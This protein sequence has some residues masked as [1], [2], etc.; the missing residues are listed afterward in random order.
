MSRGHVGDDGERWR[1]VAAEPSSE[2][3]EGDAEAFEGVDHGGEAGGG[4]APG[5]S[6][7]REE[8]KR[9]ER[10]RGGVG[11]VWSLWCDRVGVGQ[12]EERERERRGSRERGLN[13]LMAG[14]LGQHESYLISVDSVQPYY[15]YTY[16]LKDYK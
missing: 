13:R 15:N 11:G 5:V 8:R 6:K 14:S 16:P 4:E 2:G 7:E 1:G 12:C 3:L 9:S 10:R